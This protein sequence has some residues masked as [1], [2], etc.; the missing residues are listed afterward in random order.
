MRI[1]LQR[2]KRASVEVAGEIVGEIGP[3]LLLLLGVTHGDTRSDADFLVEKT[4]NLRIFS[5][6]AGKMNRSVKEVGGGIL[7]VSQFTLYGDCRKG[8]RP[9]FDAAAPPE[10]AREL[11]EYFVERMRAQDVPVGTGVFQASMQVELVN[12]G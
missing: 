6:E 7:V 9:A 8:R 1:V 12:D 2:V 5:D 3:G 11:Y 4:V 10:L